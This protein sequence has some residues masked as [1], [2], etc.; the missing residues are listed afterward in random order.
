MKANRSF[1]PL[2]GKTMMSP[3]MNQA[4]ES[5]T[6]KPEPLLVKTLN[7]SEQIKD[8]VEACAHELSQVNTVL[9]EELLEH[10]PLEEVHDALTQSEAIEDKV[11]E[12]AEDL[13]SVNTA[14]AEEISER[15]ALEQKL[16]DSEVQEEKHRYLA[17]HDVTT[18]LANRTL[19][20]DRLNHALAQAERHAWSLA[21][22]FIDLDK[23][24]SINDT[25]GHDIG[26]KVLQTVGERLQT[27]VREE[28]TV[29]RIGGDEFLCLLME[30][31]EDATVANI[32]TS[33]IGKISEACEFNDLKLIVQ[34]SIG[35][36]IYPR[37]GKTAEVLLK[38]ADTAMYKAKQDKEGY[39][40]FNFN[41]LAVA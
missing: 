27:C 12:C 34:P 13:Q 30:V 7:Q 10:F 25:Y 11:Q 3:E 8:K 39:C 17:Y 18:G 24:K 40:F 36:A 38:N 33:I 26:D 14:L 1:M 37:D 22:M 15:K 21:I 19:F 2:I 23:F 41:R 29:S 20:N 31:N 4:L 32:A 6:A 35:I 28:D 16:C 9:K 5:D